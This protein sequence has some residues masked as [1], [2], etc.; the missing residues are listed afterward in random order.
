MLI[1]IIKSS[2]QIMIFLPKYVYAKMGVVNDQ[3]T[4]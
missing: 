1:Q 2:E 3:V 4:I